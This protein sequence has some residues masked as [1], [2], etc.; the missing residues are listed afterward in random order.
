MDFPEEC[1]FNAESYR[2]QKIAGVN[3]PSASSAHAFFLTENF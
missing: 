3:S 2:S 1:Y